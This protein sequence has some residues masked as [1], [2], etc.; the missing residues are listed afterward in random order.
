M[1]TLY[2]KLLMICKK[3]REIMLLATLDKLI[4]DRDEF[5]DKTDQLLAFQTTVKDHEELSDKIDQLQM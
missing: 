4:Q 1:R 3:I 2:I 5:C